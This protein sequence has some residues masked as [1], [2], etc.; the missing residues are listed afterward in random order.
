MTF[1]NEITT[2]TVTTAENLTLLSDPAST[3]KLDEYIILNG[4]DVTAY[5]SIEVALFMSAVT[6]YTLS[7]SSFIQVEA[8]YQ[9][10]LGNTIGFESFRC[11]LRDQ[12]TIDTLFSLRIPV[13][14]PFLVLSYLWGGTTGANPLAINSY[15]YGSTQSISEPSIRQHNYSSE[16]TRNKTGDDGTVLVL[17]NLNVSA[18][19]SVQLPTLAGIGSHT[20]SL[21]ASGNL[22]VDVRYTNWNISPPS[23]L[24]GRFN[25]TTAPFTQKVSLPNGSLWFIFTNNTA[26]AITVSGSMIKD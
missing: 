18:N 21:V 5:S 15:A 25:I 8:E 19:S 16:S 20:L 4:I 3:Q 22:T 24:A 1:S 13:R 9:D 11:H 26:S 2:S 23:L 6:S 17:D 10:S 14:G 7:V 12:R